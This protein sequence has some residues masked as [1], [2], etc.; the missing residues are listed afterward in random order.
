VLDDDGR[1]FLCLD[2]VDRPTASRHLRA[3]S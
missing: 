1:E 3:G 2:C